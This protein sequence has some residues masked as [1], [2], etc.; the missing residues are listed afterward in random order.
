MANRI[1]QIVASQS[2]P[3]KEDEFNRWY[4]E[5]HLPMLFGFK[6]VKQASR[7]KYIG[8]PGD[9]PKYLAIY[10]FESE[11]ALTCDEFV[12]KSASPW[13]KWVRSWYT[14]KVC[15]LYRQIYP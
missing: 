10:E 2:T 6:G 9:S 1:I 13:T 8:L 3:D 5:V 15:T 14:R 11:E 7:Y 4:N 12:N